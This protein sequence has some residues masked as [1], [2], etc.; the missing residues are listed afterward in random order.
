MIDR[1]NI[2]RDR[3]KSDDMLRHGSIMVAFV[4]GGSFF[5]YLY[6]LSMGRLLTPAEYGALISLLSLLTIISV[7]GQ[8]VDL[9][10]TNF[11]SKEK[12]RNKMERINYLWRFLLK[13]TLLLGVALFLILAL[14]TPLISRFLKMDNN[15]YIIVLGFSLVFVFAIPVNLG[16]LR[17]LQRFVPLGLAGGIAAL[18]KFSVA[19]LLVYLGFGLYGGLSS[20]VIANLLIF[21]IGLF[22]LRDLTRAGNEKIETGNIRSY[23]GLALLAIV[24]FTILTNIDVILAKHYLN[25]ESVGDY[26]ALS[27]VGKIAL[28]VPGGIVIAMFPKTSELF[29]KGMGHRPT[30]LKAMLF[31]LFLAGGVVMLYWLFPGF[32]ITFIFGSKY[33]VTIPYLYKYGLA[34]L[35]FA[36]SFLSMNYFLSLNETRIGYPLVA[37]AVLEVVL[38]GFFHSDINQITNMMLICGI[39]SVVL[40]L[41][42]YIGVVKSYY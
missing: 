11:V 22:F 28:Y 15:W 37:V 7:F 16:T 36:I 14:L 31:T 27:V 2:L 3:I 25:P 30:L 20:F 32:I 1:V 29:E 40:M 5:N 9:S 21:F 10:V 26:S 42:F 34:M 6:Q 19:V 13:R 24:C 18:F 4:L 39:V 35:F 17:G 41:P 23:T 12:A 8:T 33:L 38:I